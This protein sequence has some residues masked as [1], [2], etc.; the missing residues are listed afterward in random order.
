MQKYL[1]SQP[2]V[3]DEKGWTVDHQVTLPTFYHKEW[4]FWLNKRS[5]LKLEYNVLSTSSLFLVIAQGKDSYMKWIQDIGNPDCCLV[6]RPVQ[7]HGHITFE[8]TKDDDYYIGI[9]RDQG[10]SL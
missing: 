9:D 1:Q 6:W 2:S 3:D 5:K 10:Q 8:T 7:F 4:S